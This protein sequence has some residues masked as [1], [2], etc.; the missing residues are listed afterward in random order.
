MDEILNTGYLSRTYTS[1]SVHAIA[2]PAYSTTIGVTLL[3]DLITNNSKFVCRT[4]AR[5]KNVATRDSER[6]RNTLRRW[7]IVFGIYVTSSLRVFGGSGPILPYRFNTQRA[8]RRGGANHRSADSDAARRYA[9]R[10]YIINGSACHWCDSPVSLLR[11]TD[12]LPGLSR[13]PWTRFRDRR[14]VK[15]FLQKFEAPVTSV[16]LVFAESRDRII[17]LLSNWSLGDTMQ[18]TVHVI[19]VI[20]LSLINFKFQHDMYC[21]V[22]LTWYNNR[23]IAAK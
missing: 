11:V 7:Q 23:R 16:E 5:R 12:F 22:L 6:E 17:R 20:V 2:G 18:Q 19:S 15:S 9:P 4:Q 10:T 14:P 8:I 21:Q 1:L 3:L 13:T